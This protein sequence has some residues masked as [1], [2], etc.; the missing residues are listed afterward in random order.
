MLINSDVP[1]WR[2]T[3]C[4]SQARTS[5]TQQRG[6]IETGT[7]GLPG[8]TNQTFL[9]DV[10]LISL[11]CCVVLTAAAGGVCRVKCLADIAGGVWATS[12]AVVLTQ[13]EYRWAEPLHIS[14]SMPRCSIF[15]L[16]RNWRYITLCTASQIPS[17]L[18]DCV[19]MR[20][21]LWVCRRSV[22][23]VVESCNNWKFCKL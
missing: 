8:N 10:A 1:G 15:I 12:Q 22:F 19:E 9:F 7:S 6:I 20:Q 23:C 5:P 17:E 14:S 21:C 18:V 2:L 4:S 16:F 11:C 3:D 13:G